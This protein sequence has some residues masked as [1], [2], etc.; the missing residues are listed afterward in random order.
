MFSLTLFW[1]GVGSLVKI[2]KLFEVSFGVLSSFQELIIFND[3]YIL[4]QS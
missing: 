4:K 1:G 3:F 2:E